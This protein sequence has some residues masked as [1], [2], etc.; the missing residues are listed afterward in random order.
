MIKSKKMRWAGNVARMGKR[1]N[2]YMILV[3]S[4]KEIGQQEVQNVGRWIIL[5]WVWYGLD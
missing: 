5:K 1:T 3:G 4:Q 2:A